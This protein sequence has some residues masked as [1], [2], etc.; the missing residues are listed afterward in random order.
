M[1][2]RSLAVC[3]IFTGNDFNPAFYRKGKKRP[4][5]ILKNN[6]QFQEAFINLIQSVPSQVTT[7]SAIFKL[8]EEYVCRMYSLKIKNDVDKGRYE[9]FAKTYKCSNDNEEVLKKKIRSCDASCLPPSK[10]ELL[11]HLKRTI[12]I[13]SIWCNAHMRTPTEKVPDDCG[14]ALIEQKYEYYWFDGPASPSFN[15]ISAETIG[16][17]LNTYF[18]RNAY[19]SLFTIIFNFYRRR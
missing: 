3:H 15:E 6:V 19:F 10:Q 4:F 18:I 5:A 9:M 17:F 1:F 11:Q 14:W 12:Y 13:S 8:I 16:I 7:S 2:S